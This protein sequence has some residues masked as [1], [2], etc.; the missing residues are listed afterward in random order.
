MAGDH[1]QGISSSDVETKA[2]EDLGFFFAVDTGRRGEGGGAL[3]SWDRHQSPVK[4]AIYG[5]GLLVGYALSLSLTLTLLVL[6]LLRCR[7]MWKCG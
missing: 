6:Q 3:Y 5:E 7:E 1:T 2:T 4:W